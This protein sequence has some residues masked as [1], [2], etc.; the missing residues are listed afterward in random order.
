VVA[1]TLNTKGR[2]HR[3]NTR[4]KSVVLPTPDGP[5]KTTSRPR[6]SAAIGS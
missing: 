1:D 3:A 4:A 2:A 6:V 5:E